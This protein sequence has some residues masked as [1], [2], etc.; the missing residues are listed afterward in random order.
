MAITYALDHERRRVYTHAHGLLTYAELS[1]H[2]NAKMRDE[3]AGWDEL[4]DATAV[5]TDLTAE[6][7]RSLFL[8]VLPMLEKGLVG[9]TGIVATNPVVFGMARMYATLCE[10]VGVTVRVFRTVAEAAQWLDDYLKTRR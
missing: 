5:D 9:A 6:Q 8:H 10:Q 1:T 3:R 7:V 4:F 2:F